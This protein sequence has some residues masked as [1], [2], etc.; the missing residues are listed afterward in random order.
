MLLLVRSLFLRA[1]GFCALK[2]ERSLWQA[3]NK[4]LTKISKNKIH[5]FHPGEKV[6]GALQQVSFSGIVF[7][8][9]K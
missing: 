6:V 9:G 5:P 3:I 4:N 7:A 2:A 1:D 8:E